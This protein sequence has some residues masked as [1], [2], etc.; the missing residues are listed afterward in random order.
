MDEIRDRITGIESL[1]LGDVLDNPRNPKT[2]PQ[3]QGDALNG[4]VREIGWAGV[5]LVYHSERMGGKL[6]F[7]DGHLRKRQF[8]NLTVRAAITDLT[9][10]EADLLLLTFD[11]IAALAQPEK[12]AMDALLK[13][14]NSGEAAVQELLAKVAADAGLTYGEPP[15]QADAEPQIDRAAELNKKWAVNPGDLWRIGDHRL[16]CGDSTLRA[17]VERVM[18]GEKANIVIADP[19]YGMKLDTDFSGMTSA[20]SFGRGRK[21]K[22]VIG[23]EKPFD[24]QSV[25]GCD[26][27]EQFWFGADYYA[28]SIGDTEQS[29]SWLV[30]DKRLTDSA[31]LIYGSS[32]ELIFSKQKHKRDILR[33]LWAGFFTGGEER[34]FDHP[35]EKPV[36]LII[37]LINLCNDA[38]VIY[39]PFCGCGPSLVACQNLSRK[40]RAIEISP[41]YCAVILERM[42]TA[43][44]GIAIERVSDGG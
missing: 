10:A 32:F 15:A 8:P 17:D 25:I 41:E 28:K 44:P 24:A 7:V 42:A 19:P 2:H 18:D 3:A 37:D 21:H 9:D 36:S 22:K 30:W 14:V 4:I 35:T 27:K 38:P 29:G 31:G 5:P 13:S 16:L 6:A 1:R 11:P 40:C 43:F 33:H 23:D 20:K 26:C 34:T 39:D 12:Q